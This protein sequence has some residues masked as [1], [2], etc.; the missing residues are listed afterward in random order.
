MAKYNL[1]NLGQR[2]KKIRKALNLTQTEFGASLFVS[3]SHIS[4]IEKGSVKCGFNVI[5]N[6]SEIHNVSL[7]YL[8]HGESEMFGRK[9][10]QA[11]LK[12]KKVGDAIESLSEL[13]WYLE[14][15]PLML[16]TLMG[17]ATKF[18]YENEEHIK[19]DIAKFNN[20][21]KEEETRTST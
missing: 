14:R 15:S 19:K 17:I 6:L 8:V 2:I 10:T 1:E 16:Y 21:H 12:N 5:H 11:S 18:L 9:R 7:Y 3:K 4:D 13:F 20:A